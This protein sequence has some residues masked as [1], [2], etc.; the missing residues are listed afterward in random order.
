MPASFFL[1]SHIHGYTTVGNTLVPLSY[2]VNSGNVQVML[3]VTLFKE[4]N[5]IFHIERSAWIFL[6]R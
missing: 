2:T 1:Y 3:P 6:K 4:K 5:L